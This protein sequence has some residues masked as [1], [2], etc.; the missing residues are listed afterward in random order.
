MRI[1]GIG[2]VMLVACGGGK[3]MVAG[4]GGQDATRDAPVDVMLDARPDAPVDSV[5][6]LI[7]APFPDASVG[8]NPL[9]QA[10]CNTGEKCNWIY[11]QLMPT[12]VGH[13]GCEPEGATAL[14]GACGPRAVGPDP[15]VKGSECIGEECRQICDPQGGSPTC[16]ALHA[17]TRYQTLFDEGGT[18]VAGVCDARCDPLTQDLASGTNRTACGSTSPTMPDRGCYGYG[19]YSC[20]GVAPTV[21]N[22]VALTLTDRVAP[23]GDY[24]NAC[25]PGFM[26]LLISETGSS[27]GLCNGLCAALETDNTPAH[28]THSKGDATALAKLPTEAAPAAGNATCDIGRKGSE[29]SSVC[30]FLWPYL[31]DSSGGLVVTGTTDTLGVCMATAHYRF[32]SN[33][34]G[35]IDAN[36]MFQS[37]LPCNTLPPR[38]AATPG[39]ND[40]AADFGCQQYAH[41]MFTG[42]SAIPA[43]TVQSWQSE[44][45]PGRRHRFE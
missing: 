44:P 23:A 3:S 26:P 10:G 12:V 5:V 16:D 19:D 35:I 34:D 25:A 43:G 40:D 30:K 22:A 13:I 37:A 18:N 45:V 42:A 27:T 15:C 4:D 17:C 31:V 2:V 36:D 33:G 39:A 38:S 24:L 9:T 41:A 11:D 29:T 6:V 20:S 7:D 8:C 14:G 1:L 28:V 21:T 32:D